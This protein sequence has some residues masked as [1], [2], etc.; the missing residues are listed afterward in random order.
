MQGELFGNMLMNQFGQMLNAFRQGLN[1]P[2]ASGTASSTNVAS[3]KAVSI[4]HSPSKQQALQDTVPKSRKV[5]PIDNGGD[6]SQEP[7]QAP[8][9]PPSMAPGGGGGGGGG[10]FNLDTYSESSVS[11]KWQKADDQK[12]F[13]PTG[14]V[15]CAAMWPAAKGNCIVT[16]IPLHLRPM[17]S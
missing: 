1:L 5:L 10:T 13:V 14:V 12:V 17:M 4:Q 2:G 8:S 11:A 7:A 15:K 6:S 9:L 3:T 16:I